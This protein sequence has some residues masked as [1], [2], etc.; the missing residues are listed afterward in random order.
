MKRRTIQRAQVLA[1]VTDMRC[2]PTAEEVF[3]HATQQNP[4]ISRGTIYRNLAQLAQEGL[5]RRVPVPNA[6]DRFDFTTQPH[7]HIMCQNCGRFEDV[8]IP[9]A[10]QADMQ[11]SQATGWQCNNHEVIFHG[12]CNDCLKETKTI[13]L[14]EE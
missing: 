8:T 11:V 13:H 7:Y 1:A 5:I 4:T 6:S 9:Y 2:H 10:A 3:L 14:Q 12:L